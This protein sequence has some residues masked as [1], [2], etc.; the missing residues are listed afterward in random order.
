MAPRWSARPDSPR[1]RA[2]LPLDTLGA[3]SKSQWIATRRM[4]IR[5]LH[6]FGM[7][8]G[9]EGETSG[10]C[11]RHDGFHRTGC[12]SYIMV[13]IEEWIR[14]PVLPRSNLVYKTSACAALPSRNKMGRPGWIRAINL[15]SQSRALYLELQG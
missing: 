13:S 6:D 2:G 1:I 10:I 11:T 9:K 12:C 15:P 8:R 14:L 5:R 7:S 4:A 3:M